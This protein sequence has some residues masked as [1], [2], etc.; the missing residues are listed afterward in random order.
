MSLFRALAQLFVL[1]LALASAASAAGTV[2][3]KESNG[4]MAVYKPVRVRLVG[5]TLWL[6]SP[7]GKD[8]LQIVSG[9]C[10]YVHEIQRCLPFKVVLHRSGSSHE[11]SIVRGVYYVNLTGEAHALLHSPERIPPHSILA[12]LHTTHG[13]FVQARG[14]LDA[15]Q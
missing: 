6:R 15:V 9:A 5:H 2:R 13:T 14:R 10:S 7:D 8:R 12:F 1:F 11:L 4:T 3:V